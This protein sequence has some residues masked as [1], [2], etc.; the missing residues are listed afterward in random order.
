MARRLP[1]TV[2][3]LKRVSEIGDRR[4][5][6]FGEAILAVIAEYV[7]ATGATPVSLD[8]LVSRPR[9]TKGE[10]GDTVLTTLELFEAGHDTASIAEM[11]SLRQS[12]IEGHLADAIE[13]GQLADPERFVSAERRSVIEAA[14]NEVG[15]ERLSPVIEHLGEGYTYLELRVVRALMR[16]EGTVP[17][18]APSLT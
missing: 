14:M 13:A 9:K 18:G 2:Q 15:V 7:D 8:P 16:R 4:A 5:A 6:D 11:R 12:T 10:L 17:A 1:R 3:E